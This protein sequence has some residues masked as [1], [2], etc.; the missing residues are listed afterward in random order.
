M[1]MFDF[2]KPST[3]DKPNSYADFSEVSK[4][5]L[6]HYHK[7]KTYYSFQPNPLSGTV[8]LYKYR[9]ETSKKTTQGLFPPE[10]IMIY[11]CKTTNKYPAKDGQ[12]YPA[13]WWFEYGIVDVDSFL[14]SLASRQYIELVNDTY[15]PTKQGEKILSENEAIIW[16]H[17]TKNLGGAWNILNIL[18]DVPP[19]MVNY[20]WKD[21]VWYHFNKQANDYLDRANSGEDTLGLYRNILLCQAQFLE[22]EKKYSEAINLY[23]KVLKVD[24]KID[25]IEQK[26][27]E[28][29]DVPYHKMP[30]APGILDSIKKLRKK[31]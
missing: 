26:Q 11:F 5:N 9:M 28:E 8:I 29:L 19:K 1:G 25:E 7:D 2:L 10:V 3:N 31:L 12:I 23:H 22:Y 16:A 30:P 18:D 21:K 14:E 17:K 27:C 13:Y 6:K 4:E 20:S 15:K 24:L